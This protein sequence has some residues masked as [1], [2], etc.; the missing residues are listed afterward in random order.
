MELF[1]LTRTI[2]V[3]CNLINTV[4]KNMARDVVLW[5]ADVSRLVP[6][7]LRARHSR[8]HPVNSNANSVFGSSGR[9]FAF[10]FPR[11][12][13]CEEINSPGLCQSKCTERLPWIP[14][15]M[16]GPNCREEQRT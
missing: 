10:S 1:A 14:I 13:E 6:S 8:P 7:E 5:T 16:R 11:Y 2:V 12:A 15:L 3:I 9:F 4:R